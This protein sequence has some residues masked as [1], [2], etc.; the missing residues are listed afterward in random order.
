M[1]ELT[2][3]YSVFA[4]QGY[5]VEPVFIT[6]IVDREGNVLEEAAPERIKVIEKTTAYLMT[7][8]LEGV[9][10]H[11]TGWRAKALNRPVAGKTGTTNNLFDAWFMGYTPQYITGTWVGFD[12]E[13]PL[14]KSETGS[15][16]ASPIWLGFMKRVLEDKPPK[17][18]EVPEGIVFTKIDAETGL[19]PIPESK[20]TVFVSFKEGT[21]PT[22]YSKRPGDIADT[23]EFFKKDL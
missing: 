4:N 6:K 18:F 15:R 23:G 19:L 10:K 3:A 1:L 12:D 8:L 9:V 2:E 14:G 13:A 22:E 21:E 11:G 16:A 7:H 5:L 20:E 17:I